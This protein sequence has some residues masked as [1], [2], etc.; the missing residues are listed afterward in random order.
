M[1]SR[2]P[3]CDTI[4]AMGTWSRNRRNCSLSR[5]SAKSGVATSASIGLDGSALRSSSTVVLT[6]S[7]VDRT[8]GPI[9]RIGERLSNSPLGP[10]GELARAWGVFVSRDQEALMAGREKGTFAKAQSSLLKALRDFQTAV[11]EITVTGE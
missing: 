8:I 9:P 10:A 6:L 2:E 1:R 7:V 4:I 5:A 11:S 3:I